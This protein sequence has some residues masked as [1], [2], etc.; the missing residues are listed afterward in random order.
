MA[1]R[2]SPVAV[3]LVAVALT[4]G[5]RKAAAPTPAPP[6]TEQPPAVKAKPTLSPDELLELLRRG[7][8]QEQTRAV[9]QIARLEPAAAARVVP[10]LVAALKDTS[11]AAGPVPRGRFASTREAA[12]AALLR[13]GPKAEAEL[14]ARGVPALADGLVSDNP[15]LRRATANALALLGPKVRPAANALADAARAKE[16]E[17]RSAALA[18]LRPLGADAA[19]LLLPNLADNDDAVRSDTAE[20]IDWM[21]PLPASAVPLLTAAL[22]EARK[23]KQAAGDA[24]AADATRRLN[25]YVLRQ[26]CEGLA[27]AGPAAASAVPELLAAFEDLQLLAPELP[28]RGDGRGGVRPGLDSGVQ[29]ALRAIGPAAVPELV[30]EVSSGK[31][32]VRWQAVMTLGGMGRRATKEVVPALTKA[33]DDAEPLVSLEAAAALLRLG[34]DPKVPLARLVAQLKSESAQARF[35]ALEMLRH[36]GKAGPG[37]AEAV[38]ALLADPEPLIRL[39]AAG[40][41]RAY[42][43]GAAGTVPGLAKLVAEPSHGIDVAKFPDRGAAAW[44][45][46][47]VEAAQTLG[48]MG[49]AAKEAVPVLVAAL[50]ADDPN[51]RQAAAEALRALGPTAAGAADGLIATAAGTSEVLDSRLTALEALEAI[52]PAAKGAVPRLTALLAD[53]EARVRLGAARALAASGPA[54]AAAAAALGKLVTKDAAGEVRLAAARALARLGDAARPA[55]DDLKAASASKLGEVRVWASYALARATGEAAAAVAPL[56]KV[57]ADP[58]EGGPARTAAL[59]ALADLAPQVPAALKAVLDA[60]HDKTAATRQAAAAALGGCGAAAKEVV[61]A[62]VGLTRDPEAAVQRSA[63]ESL[64]RIGPAATAGAGRLRDLAA[65]DDELGRAARAALERIEPGG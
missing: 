32:P 27:S 57:L 48:R 55:A 39:R 2:R 59:E 20:T 29:K 1:H 64:G 37:A 11:V 60:A 30:K 21:K 44:P 16:P 12:T 6:P 46:I 24:P 34:A 52:G 53:P 31:P 7:N 26:A 51:V 25:D 40:A 58:K 10:G 62:L 43:P 14:V 23:R 4:A 5:C 17:V 33:M 15:E 35:R 18:A 3:L 8:S 65:N 19:P 61:P 49:A 22:A 13:L 50:K 41:L 38:T 54:A 63:V 56:A 9:E 47:Q 28:G 45:Q 36:A 42:G